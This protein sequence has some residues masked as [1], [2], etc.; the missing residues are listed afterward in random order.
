MAAASSVSL[1]LT[2]IQTSEETLD[3][4]AAFNVSKVWAQLVPN[5][6]IQLH[7]EQVALSYDV[8]WA[9]PLWTQWNLELGSEQDQILRLLRRAILDLPSSLPGA[10][11]RLDIEV[12]FAWP[13]VRSRFKVWLR[14]SF[15]HCSQSLAVFL[16]ATW[17]GM[18][19]VNLNPRFLQCFGGLV[20][21]VA[22]LLCK[23]LF[24]RYLGC[25][26][27]EQWQPNLILAILDG[28]PPEPSLAAPEPSYPAEPAAAVVEMLED[29]LEKSLTSS[30]SSFAKVSAVRISDEENDSE[31]S[32]SG[33]GCCLHSLHRII[34]C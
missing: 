21:L 33:F 16:D 7:Y 9:N 34:T 26:T 23:F 13:M 4:V 19:A 27:P 5:G 15:W 30:D 11:Q 17:K 2:S 20:I 6:R 10:S 31:Y 29:E 12:K 18:G 25:A 3:L 8:C 1:A 14:S 32:T 28:T 22:F 24:S